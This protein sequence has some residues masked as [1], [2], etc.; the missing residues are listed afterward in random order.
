VLALLI[1]R[2]Q[3]VTPV[4]EEIPMVL[5]E[6]GPSWEIRGVVK[7]LPA[8][9]STWAGLL[10]EDCAAAK[11]SSSH[12]ATGSTAVE[13]ADRVGFRREDPWR[14]SPNRECTGVA[15]NSSVPE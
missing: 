3:G 10:A 8:P 11:A 1:T 2:T 5:Q 14:G 15:L 4:Y 12:A 13:I 7:I 6:V 9:I